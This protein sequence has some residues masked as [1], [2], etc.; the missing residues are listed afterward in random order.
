MVIKKISTD[1][2]TKSQSSVRILAL[3]QS[4]KVTGWALLEFK[5]DGSINLLHYGILNIHKSEDGI[6]FTRNQRISVLSD[7]VTTLVKQTKPDIIALET[8]F[9]GQ[10]RATAMALFSCFGALILIAH[11][12]GLPLY[13]VSPAT[14]KTVV[15][16]SN[17]W[18]GK[19]SKVKVKKALMLRFGVTFTSTSDKVCDDSDAVAV[20]VAVIEKIL[21]L[22]KPIK[23]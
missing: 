3:D 10:N 8:P 19:D 18:K 12:L 14:A 16:G 22:D 9:V 15:L 13:D 11:Q 6:D 2:S 23:K 20:G 21:K 17:N 1:S 4:T 7:K 5:K